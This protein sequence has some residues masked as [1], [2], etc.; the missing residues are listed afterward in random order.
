[1]DELK[2]LKQQIALLNKEIKLLQKA[3]KKTLKSRGP[4]KSTVERDREEYH[5]YMR[6]LILKM[7]DPAVVMTPTEIVDCNVY[8]LRGQ[9]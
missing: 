8:L 6:G 4:R 7:K 9:N 1:M 3:T 5:S 2:A